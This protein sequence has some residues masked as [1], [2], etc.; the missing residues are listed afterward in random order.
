[1]N[2][3]RIAV[4]SIF[5]CLFTCGFSLPQGDS[6]MAL[7][8]LEQQ[9]F[10]FLEVEQYDSAAIIGEELLN[11]AYR[12]EDYHGYVVSGHICLGLV[13][14]R[15]GNIELAMGHLGQAHSNALS[16]NNPVVQESFNELYRLA[17]REHSER[18]RHQSAFV[19]ALIALIAMFV[20][21]ALLVY[22]Y[23][24]KNRLYEAIVRL[25]HD[26]LVREQLC[27]NSVRPKV[28]DEK[29]DELV[30]RLE[31]LMHEEKLYRENLLTRDKVADMLNT[32]RTYLGQIMSEVYQK[33]FTQYINDLRIDEAIRL[34]DNPKSTR[35][36]RLIGQN[37]G[38][39]SVTTFN[40]QFQ[41]RTGMTP[42]QYRKKVLSLSRS[43]EE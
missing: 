17:Q 40:A 30:Q 22:F 32:N 11:E 35:P 10:H 37:L 13:S 4:L 20:I 42:A 43:A 14:A 16:D 15:S 33:S 39:N 25:N 9:A 38:F 41:N 8:R 24:Q 29:R 21:L 18:L 6:I 19:V 1:M 3:L 27:K 31:L 28:N 36:V 12:I 23:W 26:N 5:S 2:L 7:E 34:L